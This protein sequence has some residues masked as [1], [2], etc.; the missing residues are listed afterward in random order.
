MPR[1]PS[2][3]QGTWFQHEQQILERLAGIPGVPAPAR[4]PWEASPED[5]HRASG[6]TLADALRRWAPPAVPEQLELALELAGIL[7]AVHRAGV[8]HGHLNPATA[9]LTGSP[10][11]VMIIGFRHATTVAEREPE[12]SH[13]D[14]I[15]GTLATLAPEQTGRTG[16]LVDQRADLYGLGVVLYHLATGSLPFEQHDPLRLVHD[17]LAR[18][19]VPPAER[20]DL[21]PI[22]SAIIMRLLEKEP[23]QRYQSAE[24]LIHDLYELRERLRRGQEPHFP[25]GEHDFPHRLSAPTRL[26]GR[27]SEI[28]ALRTALDEAVRGSCKAVLVSGSPGVGKTTLI[29]ELR[30]MVTSLGGWF[31]AGKSDQYR[32]DLA[33]DAVAQA[34]RALGRLLLTEP[35]ADLLRHRTR[36]L[37]TVGPNAKLVA[38]LQ[39]EIALVLGMPTTSP[40]K[41]EACTRDRMV[42]AGMDVLRSVA[43]SEHPLVV[44][45]DDLQWASETATGLLE[46]LFQEDPHPGLLIV[47]AY[48]PGEIDDKHPLST[49]MPRWSRSA[50]PPVV[51]QPENLPTADLSAMLSEMLRLPL[52]QA[53]ALASV[54]GARTG[55]NP[56]DTV[57]F[58]NAMREEGALVRDNAGWWW[59]EA[60]IQLRLGDGDVVDL[61]GKRID[62]LPERTGELLSRMAC[63]GGEADADLLRLASGL[64]AQELETHLAPALADGLLVMGHHGQDQATMTVR[65]RHDRVQQAATSRLEPGRLRAM[66][67]ALARRLAARPEF[68]GLAAEQYL[69][70]IDD[71]VTTEERRRVLAVFRSAADALRL[72]NPTMAERF[73]SAALTMLSGEERSRSWWSP[74]D[75]L[76]PSDDGRRRIGVELAHHAALYHLGRLA[77]ADARYESI[78]R[79]SPTAVELADAACDR[80]SS[81]TFRERPLEAV[82]LGL[83][84]LRHLG[85]EVPAPEQIGPWT[86]QGLARFREWAAQEDGIAAD[87]ARPEA[88]DPYAAAAARLIARMIPPA[89]F[90]GMPIMPWLMLECQRLWAEHGPCASLIGPLSH[91]GFVNMML[92]QDPRTGYVAI[93]RVIA[94]CEKHGYEPECSHAKLIL[95]LSAGQ[96]FEPLERIVDLANRALAGLLQG[97]DQQNAGFAAYVLIPSA[98]ECTPTLDD[99]LTQVNARLAFASSTGNDQTFTALVGY[100]Q[101]ARALLGRTRQPGS[102]A[103]ESFDPAV[104]LAEQEGNPVASAYARLSF[105]LRS[106]IFGD[107]EELAEHSAAALALLPAFEATLSTSI[108]RLLR[109]LALAATIRRLTGREPE[110]I[111]AHAE[112]TQAHAE[113]TPGCADQGSGAGDVTAASEELDCCREWLAKRA[114]DSDVNFGH[115]LHLVDAERAWAGGDLLEAARAFDL[116]M[117]TV[118][119]RQ[120]PWH[121]ALITE[122]AARF[123]L[124]HGLQLTGADLMAR[125][126]NRYLAWGARAKVEA[127]ESE[128]PELREPELRERVGAAPGGQPSGMAAAGAPATATPAAADRSPFATSGGDRPATTTAGDH[129]ATTAASEWIASTR[130]AGERAAGGHAAG[131]GAAE[132][133]DLMAVLQACQALSSETSLDR[134]YTRI[135]EV[136]SAA[137][138]ATSVRIVLRRE[139]SRGWYVPATDPDESGRSGGIPLSSPEGSRLVP[140]L[141]FRYAERTLEPVL[142]A[143]VASDPR[144]TVDPYLRQRGCRSLLV[145]PILSHGSPRAMLILEHNLSRGAFTAVRLDAVRLIAGQL[146][147]S[148]ENAMFYEELEERVRERTREL[149]AT[150]DELVDMARHVGMAEIAS[151][152]LTTIDKVL[153]D[154][155]TSAGLVARRARTA[156][157]DTL[158]KTVGLIRDHQAD[159]GDYLTRDEQG[160][161]LPECLAR[162][163]IALEAERRDIAEELECLVGSVNRMTDIIATQQSHASGSSLPEPTSIGAL[164][165]DA[166]RINAEGLDRHRVTIVRRFGELPDVVLDK[167]KTLLILVNLI[168]NAKAAVTATR[169]GPRVVMVSAE[170]NGGRQL[171][172]RV[173]DSGEGIRPE[174]L[175]RIFTPGFST[176]SGGHGFGLH[177]CALAA[178]DMG[179][180]LMGAS[181]GPGRGATFVLDLPVTTR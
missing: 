24:G 58:L 72:V 74:T 86:E 112:R 129:P 45:L 121:A 9:L 148:L 26:V 152:V 52:S 157:A 71:I 29:N 167:V 5:Q 110:R 4:N 125:A 87:L 156:T 55:G 61:L 50:R 85:F 106:A 123:H 57:A 77:E 44:V 107:S 48:R 171:R 79:L 175:S 177:N 42:R 98:L 147:V 6:I 131:E 101:L 136:L 82:E 11:R 66:H 139:D 28:T 155:T 169:G 1:V 165:E 120:R 173:E 56:F 146:A 170:L 176:R 138:G 20:V 116:A 25:L 33:A 35:E 102:L 21:P 166:I 153:T 10:P 67:L 18:M 40:G 91:A 109:A 69:P 90:V 144:F 143:D 160:K 19:P 93:R 27:D 181:E 8:T 64:S 22:L 97:G 159:L 108:A 34:L 126:R 154:V 180:T 103:D 60:A 51:L 164:I 17:V 41:A 23:D 3:R 92:A 124:A 99:Y 151:N 122:R 84:L 115:L 36:L 88:S 59:D 89:F 158:A 142:V 68:A 105:G 65:F 15:P 140:L 150:Q 54:V 179:G 32:R 80:I 81:L 133:I 141:S 49:M 38:S 37:E 16:R 2:Q 118:R 39:P 114:A 7:A 13:H 174:H 132:T 63:L 47:G 78:E 163:S 31:V 128:Y 83:D 149:R 75:D 73:L 30:P 53:M 95:T 43:S 70:A 130:T 62:R 127:L 104:H 162:I 113:R 168:S 76:V 111:P 117:L 119:D 145:A 94:V 96:W 100:R 161:L 46:T 135:R 137:T 134:L 14:S 172:V 178:R 12:F